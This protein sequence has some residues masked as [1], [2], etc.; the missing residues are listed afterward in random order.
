MD[1]HAERR[2]AARETV[3]RTFG[4][5]L[6]WSWR[7]GAIWALLL[8]AALLMPSHRLL[9]TEIFVL[10]LFALSLDLLLGYAGIVSLGHAAYFGFG[11]YLA[12]LL[13]LHG[14]VA[15][16]VLALVVTMAATGLFG[17][18]TSVLVLRGTDLTKIMVTLGIALILR[19]I[20]NR[21][22]SLTGGADGLTGILI[23]PVLGLFELDLRG[24]TG[25][26][27]CLAV[28]FLLFAV[29]R[30]ITNSPFGYSVRAIRD[31]PVRAS[32]IGIPVNRRLM[33]IFA[34]SAAYAG[35]AGALLTQTTSFV[36]LSVLDFER[37]ADVLLMLI[38]GGTGYLYGGLA[39][40][41][42]FKLLQDWLAALSPQYWQFWMGAF[43]IAVVLLRRDRIAA[44]LAPV[45]QLISPRHANK[46]SRFRPGENS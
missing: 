28:L 29:A 22:V 18:L 43:L 30:R 25:I 7:D 13:S 42:V 41:L 17:L 2:A 12:G 3:R 8:L 44:V 16:P 32:A 21:Q 46:P 27:Y 45:L 1:A 5:R 31:N 23:D 39:G 40:A 24:T 20:A 34:I 9:L 38:I 37:S 36:S 19:E 6:D 15:E 35:A 14:W 11:A 10:A 33:G 4:A 26:F